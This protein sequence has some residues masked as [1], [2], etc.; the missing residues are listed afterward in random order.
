MKLIRKIS[1][2]KW[3]ECLKVSPDHLSADAITGCLRT[4]NNTLSLWCSD[5]DEDNK[6]S[7]LAL[8]SSLTQIATINFVYLDSDVL[9]GDS[10]EIIESIVPTAVTNG[11]ILH[12]DIVNLDHAALERVA[13]HVKEKVANDDFSTLTKNELRE[14]L[15]KG[16]KDGS[17]DESKL[18]KKLKSEL[19]KVKA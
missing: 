10:L 14:I 12:R 6:T 9:A 19:D 16:I 13:L 2:A 5:S 7:I 15:I 8:G 18:D 1:V 17:V 11:A 4:Q 3:K